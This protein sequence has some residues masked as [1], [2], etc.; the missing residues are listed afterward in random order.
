M[1]VPRV[2]CSF[3]SIHQRRARGYGQDASAVSQVFGM[4]G[5]GI[6]RSLRALVARA[7]TPRA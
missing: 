4:T 2:N 6:E 1:A 7:Q 5:Q 3:A